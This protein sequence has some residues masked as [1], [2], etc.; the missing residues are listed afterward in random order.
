MQIYKRIALF[1][2]I[3]NPNVGDE[4]ILNANLQMIYR[5]YGDNCKV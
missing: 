1:G 2:A 3:A 5:M 4:A